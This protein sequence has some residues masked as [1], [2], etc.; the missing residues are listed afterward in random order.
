MAKFVLALLAASAAPLAP[1]LAAA[2]DDCALCF[3]DARDAIPL[4]IE[5]SADLVFSRLA[6]TGNHGGSAEIDPQSGSKR[7]EG[8]VIDLGGMA[9]QGH[10]RVTGEP[11]R[12]IR[13][14][15]PQ[16]VTMTAADGSQAELSNFTTDLPDFPMLDEAGTLEFS[17]GGRL[18]LNSASGGNFRGRIPISVEYN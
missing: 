12:R 1:A 13:V 3:E 14:I 18:R 4:R 9:V 2:Q 8:A 16:Q 5:I 11:L 6:M 7:T 17:F 15:L 10:A